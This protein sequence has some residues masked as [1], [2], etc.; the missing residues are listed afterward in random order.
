MSNG[1]VITSYEK[2]TIGNNVMLGPNVLIYDQDHDYKAN[3]GIK[4]MKF[5]TSP[6]T[7]GSNVWIGANC[8]ILRGTKIGTGCVIGGGTI[9]K[10]EFPD[11][12]VITQDRVTYKVR[13]YVNES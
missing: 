9:L 6:I 10:G 5:K 8:L 1:C 7:I 12:T 2:I 4:T 11:N 13:K 3:G